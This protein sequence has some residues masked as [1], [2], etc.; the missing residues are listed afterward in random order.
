MKGKITKSIALLTAFMFVL[1]GAFMFNGIGNTV[2]AD[3]GPASDEQDVSFDRGGGVLDSIG[4][5]TSKV[6][7]TSSSM[8]RS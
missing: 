8:I 1:T 4:I 3:V 6:P 5:D 2:F 7:E